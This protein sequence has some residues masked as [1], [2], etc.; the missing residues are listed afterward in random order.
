[1]GHGSAALASSDRYHVDKK[2]HHFDAFWIYHQAQILNGQTPD[3]NSGT[4][5]RAG[6]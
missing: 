5:V 2:A 3:A 4:S 6:F 1:V